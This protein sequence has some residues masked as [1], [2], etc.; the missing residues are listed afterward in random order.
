MASMI[1]TIYAKRFIGTN[2]MAE[3]FFELLEQT[4]MQ[5]DKIGL[6]EPLR[7]AYSL[8]RAVHMW[9]LREDNGSAGGMMSRKKKPNFQFDVWWARGPKARPNSITFYFTKETF[10][11][12]REAIDHIF[13]ETFIFMDGLYG[14]ITHDKPKKRQHVMGGIETRMPGVFW[15]NY[16]GPLYVDF[17]GREKILTGPWVK[18]EELS[19]GAI[20]A[21]LADQPD[22]EILQSDRLEKQAKEYLGA[23]SFGDPEAAE[24]NPDKP[25]RCKVPSLELPEVNGE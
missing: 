17:F 25:Q 6:Y 1:G 4:N 18:T 9:T 16:F 22:K 19:S 2:E 3:Q 24:R 11:R 15:C 8:E 13:K 12:H 21:Y 7:E 10:A 14:Y 20:I 5:P 23:E